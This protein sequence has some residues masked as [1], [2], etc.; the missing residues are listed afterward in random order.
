MQPS[1]VEYLHAELE[2]KNA[3]VNGYLG[4]NKSKCHLTRGLG[5]WVR[6]H[7]NDY[8]KSKTHENIG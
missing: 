7:E 4:V 2:T 3:S 1:V 8:Q 5:K 6:K